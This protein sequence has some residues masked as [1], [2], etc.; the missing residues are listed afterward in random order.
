MTQRLT[1]N[2]TRTKNQALIT[3]RHK[4]TKAA[5][6]G[7]SRVG[8]FTA[9]LLTATARPLW[10]FHDWRMH[11]S[12][13][14]APLL[15]CPRERAGSYGRPEVMAA[16]DRGW[17]KFSDRLCEFRPLSCL[18]SACWASLAFIYINSAGFTKSWPTSVVSYTCWTPKFLRRCNSGDLNPS[19]WFV[20]A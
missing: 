4:W 1:N 14:L 13:C 12:F 6:A 16:H 3:P 18:V 5:R 7:T 15:G 10:Q 2:V 19:R 17:R 11:N 8:V 9:T 20:R